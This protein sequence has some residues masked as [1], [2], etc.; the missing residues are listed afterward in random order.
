MSLKSSKKYHT[1]DN[2]SLLPTS[3]KTSITLNDKKYKSN[4]KSAYLLSNGHSPQICQNGE[5]LARMCRGESHFSQ[6]W[7]MSNVS[8]CIES[9]E[10]VG[11]CRANV[12][13]PG[14]IVGKCRANVLS[15]GKVGRPM[16]AQAR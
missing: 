2:V 16:S 13:S 15:P 10:M 12:L 11:K 7:Q 4:L 1:K 6:R 3:K 8:E 9:G 5:L 14:K